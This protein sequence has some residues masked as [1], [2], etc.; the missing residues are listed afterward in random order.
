MCRGNSNLLRFEILILMSL[1]KDLILNTRKYPCDQEW[2]HFREISYLETLYCGRAAVLF[3]IE[4]G[5][6]CH[7]LPSAS[8][9]GYSN[10]LWCA[11][12][13]GF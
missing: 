9:S 6:V 8:E 1:I 2:C 7:K 12:A 10:M 3:T 11:M 4:D 5:T 13:E